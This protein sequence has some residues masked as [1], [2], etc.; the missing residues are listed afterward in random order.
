[1]KQNNEQELNPNS[2][3]LQPE[4]NEVSALARLSDHSDFVTVCEYLARCL[5]DQDKKNRVTRE[6][7][8]LRQ[9]QGISQALESLL[10][11][12]YSAKDDLKRM[13]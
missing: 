9:G 1:M 11:R 5:K 6:G 12:A 3:L 4:K 2:V 13:T 8:P 7:E 10:N